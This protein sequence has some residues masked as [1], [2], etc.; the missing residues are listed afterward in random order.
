MAFHNFWEGYWWIVIAGFQ[1]L[2]K[3]SVILNSDR[4]QLDVIRRS[5]ASSDPQ[6]SWCQIIKTNTSQLLNVT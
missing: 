5:E 6:D 1:D 3:I 2:S 4:Q